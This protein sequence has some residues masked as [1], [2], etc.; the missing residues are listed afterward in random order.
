MKC[1]DLENPMNGRINVTNQTVDSAAE[2]MCIDGFTLTGGDG[3]RICLAG[4][5]WS[6]QAPLCECK[7]MCFII[8]F[9]AC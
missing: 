6:G 2:Y 7:F 3:V 9:M 4:G 5:S 8:Y 1:P